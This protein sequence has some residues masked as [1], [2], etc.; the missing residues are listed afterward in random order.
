M[1]E[2][3]SDA[4]FSATTHQKVLGKQQG[5]ETFSEDQ[6]SQ[7]ASA[8]VVILK[9][10]VRNQILTA[11]VTQSV[12]ELHKLDKDIVF[13]IKPGRGL[14]RFE[15]ERKPLLNPLHPGALG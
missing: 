12:L 1:S 13:R 7:G 6:K 5:R 14:R 9:P 3:L 10:Q 15:V 11:Q 8:S 2:T 4:P